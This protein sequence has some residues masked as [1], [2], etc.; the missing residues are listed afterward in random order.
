MAVYTHNEVASAGLGVWLNADVV[1][2]TIAPTEIVLS[3]TM[4]GVADGTLTVLSGTELGSANGIITSIAR[5]SSDRTI[6]YETITGLAYS[7][8]SFGSHLPEPNLLGVATD[9]FAGSD[10]FIGYSGNDTFAGFGSSDRFVSSAGNDT[11]IGGG[12][13]LDTADYSSDPARIRVNQ[14]QNATV[15]GI[16]PD[17][18]FDGFGGTD[19]IANVRNIIGSSHGDEINGGGHDN[20]LDGGAGDDVISGFD[21][22]DTII[23][24]SGRDRLF[25]DAGNDTIYWDAADDLANVLGGAD[26]DTL[27]VVD[28]P[29]PTT[30]NLIAHEFEAARVILNDSGNVQPWSQ[31]VDEY[32]ASWQRLTRTTNNDNA[33][34]NVTT[35]DVASANPWDY[36]IYYYDAQNRLSGAYIHAD[37]GSSQ[38]FVYDVANAVFGSYTL[39]TRNATNQITNIYTLN[40][41]GSNYGFAYDVNNAFAWQ[42]SGNIVDA[43]GR[44]TQVQLVNDDG[45]RLY[46]FF[47]VAGAATVW[48]TYRN[49]VLAD[50]VTRR[51]QEGTFDDGTRWAT[52]KDLAGT[53]SWEFQTNYYNAAGVITSTVFDQGWI[54]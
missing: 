51:A 14:R 17:T 40:D 31:I 9:I 16:P 43:Q 53:E 13:D 26:F 21:G 33:T 10:V 25:G 37:V 41:D 29:V 4:N 22:N 32:N 46:T 8:I 12:P 6:V 30:F 52:F 18:V 42:T 45:S 2:L 39:T 20:R 24:G 7:A 36:F 3:N 44:L 1:I 48:T 47:D 35:Y 50:G 54:I 38:T 5:T 28:A 23:G 27:V 49:Y 34:Y 19:S 15:N 11:F